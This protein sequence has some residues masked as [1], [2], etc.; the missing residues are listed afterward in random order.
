MRSLKARIV[1]WTLACMSA[2]QHGCAGSAPVARGFVQHERHDVA[3]VGN[4][5]LVARV[6]CDDAGTVRVELDH[7]D[8]FDE[9]G[10]RRAL[11]TLRISGDPP[12]VRAGDSPRLWLEHGVVE[13]RADGEGRDAVRVFVDPEAPAMHVL[14]EGRTPRVLRVEVEP[15]PARS[16][17]PPVSEDVVIDAEA[18]PDAVAW[19]HRNG[20][21]IQPAWLAER[22]L[23]AHATLFDDPFI[24]RTAGARVEGDGFVRVGPR[25]LATDGA[26]RRAELRATA[27]CVQADG[28]DG[29][30]ERLTKMA[31]L[32]ACSDEAEARTRAWWRARGERAFVECAQDADAARLADERAR[33]LAQAGGRFAAARG[34]AEFESMAAMGD[35]DR[36]GPLLAQHAR[37][38][39]VR[40]ARTRL[41]GGTG[42]CVVD[43]ISPASLEGSEACALGSLPRF[44]ELALDHLEGTG[45]AAMWRSCSLPVIEAAI[46]HLEWRI[47]A[48]AVRAKE[49]EGLR[50][51]LERLCALDE[52]L[53]DTAGR[54]RWSRLLAASAGAP[55]APARGAAILARLLRAEGGRL[56]VLPD[57]PRERDV[58]FRLHA[59]GAWGDAEVRGGRLVRLE[60]EPAARRGD[61]A[62][63]PGWE[64]PAG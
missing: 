60:V 23:A 24:L 61:V 20:G 5:E 4:G 34:F 16:G 9:Q 48:G 27:S 13:V 49:V 15:P 41:E 52:S 2:L 22:G 55:A 25:A 12:L 35:A 14:L 54:A 33:W 1:G 45:D 6:A 8:S 46:E 19:Y 3:V 47:D 39:R 28:L 43:P 32:V 57:W 62:V 40:E 7:V 37:V 38:L 42:A 58:R 64:L 59:A 21:S 51:A 26:V 10:V 36:I 18:E 44:I 11:G 56:I 17:E 63:G 50:D 53:A 31:A 30:L 29:W